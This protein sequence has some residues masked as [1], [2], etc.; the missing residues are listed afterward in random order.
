MGTKL[1]AAPD[2]APEA[3]YLILHWSGKYFDSI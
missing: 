3:K 1:V 2:D